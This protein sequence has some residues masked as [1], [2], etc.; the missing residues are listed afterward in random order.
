MTFVCPYCGRTIGTNDA[1]FQYDLIQYHN[2][3]CDDES[4]TGDRVTDLIVDFL[5]D[6]DKYRFGEHRWA[7]LPEVFPT[8]DLLRL[9]QEEFDDV[10]G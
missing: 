7:Y 5:R 10:L 6:N 9:D 4:H 3:K 1:I 8:V 2:M